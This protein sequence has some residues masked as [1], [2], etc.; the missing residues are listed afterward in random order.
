MEI[1]FDEIEGIADRCLKIIINEDR[2]LRLCV[3]SA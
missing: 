2:D 1:T 3:K